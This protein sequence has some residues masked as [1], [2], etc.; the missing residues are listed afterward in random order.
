MPMDSAL[1][2]MHEAMIELYSFGKGNI[3]FEGLSFTQ[4]AML[5]EIFRL[6]EADGK[7]SVSAL[8]RSTGLSKATV[9]EM[10]AGLENAGYLHIE[11]CSADRRCKDI[12]VQGKAEK[13]KD[14][15]NKKMRMLEKA[16]SPGIGDDDIASLE[17]TLNRILSNMQEWTCKESEECCD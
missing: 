3:G 14:R 2:L 9:S 12:I 4:I 16:V 11:R 6:Q 7:A 8:I 1:R 15:I 17:R 13:A 5:S 10:L